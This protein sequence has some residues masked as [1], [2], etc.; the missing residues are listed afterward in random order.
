MLNPTYVWIGIA[1]VVVGAQIVYITTLR[2][3]WLLRVAL[4]NRSSLYTR[5]QLEFDEGAELAELVFGTEVSC[6]LGIL[7]LLTGMVLTTLG[8]A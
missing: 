7:A 3:G 8:A 1:L 5:S 6:Y 4:S 2:R